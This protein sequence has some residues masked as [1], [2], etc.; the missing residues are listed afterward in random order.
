MS[1][2]LRWHTL[3]RFFSLGVGRAWAVYF[4]RRLQGLSEWNTLSGGGSNAPRP[5]VSVPHLAGSGYVGWAKQARNAQK[6]I[7]GGVYA[8]ATLGSRHMQ[9]LNKKNIPENVNFQVGIISR[10]LRPSSSPQDF[11]QCHTSDRWAYCRT[12]AMPSYFDIR[13]HGQMPFSEH[14]LSLWWGRP[15]PNDISTPSVRAD[16]SS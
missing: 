1:S 9:R 2:I 13:F 15:L 8:R 3:E 14:S 12:T 16:S 4:A 6:Y 7:F 11:F 10:F 5:A